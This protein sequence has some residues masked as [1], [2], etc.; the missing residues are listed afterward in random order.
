MRVVE[1]R[2][3]SHC[4]H[5]FEESLA[6]VD[7][8]RVRQGIEWRP[9]AYFVSRQ[10]LN[11]VSICL[12]TR[13]GSTGPEVVLISQT[14]PEGGLPGSLM[15]QHLALLVRDLFRNK[16]TWKRCLFIHQLSCSRPRIGVKKAYSYK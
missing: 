1:Q 13:G 14:L 9:Q 7:Q 2:G 15:P 10:A 11:L 4:D 5:I 16:H 12:V 8:R 6:R 3:L